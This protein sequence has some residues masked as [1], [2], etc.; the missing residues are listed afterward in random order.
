MQAEVRVC[1]WVMML[2]NCQTKGHEFVSYTNIFHSVGV[3]RL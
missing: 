2:I 1:V 3:I